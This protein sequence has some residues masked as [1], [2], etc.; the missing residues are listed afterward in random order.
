MNAEKF[1]KEHSLEEISK[2]TKIS[3]ISLRLMRNKEFDKIPKVKFLGF[4]NIIQKVYNVNLN[5][6]IEEVNN[7]TPIKEIKKNSNISISKKTNNNSTLVITVFALILIILGGFLLYKNSNTPKNNLTE[8]NNTIIQQNQAIVT[9]KQTEKNNSKQKNKQ[10]SKVSSIYTN[11][12][13]QDINN[14]NE[15]NISNQKFTITVKPNNL[16]WFKAINIDTNKTK[17]FLTKNIKILPKGNYYIKFGHG[18]FN[19]TY[20]NQTISPNTRKI[21]R[22]LFENGNYKFMKKPNKFE[23]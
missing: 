16:L 20:N 4:I 23:K 10:I 13:I 17:Q 22:I 3:P 12:S 6:L 15:N 2:K 8:T 14:T 21:I 9:N 19:L 18:D 1:F 11:K 7:Q 5:D